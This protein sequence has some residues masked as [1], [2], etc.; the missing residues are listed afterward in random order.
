[1]LYQMQKTLGLYLKK[2]EGT[3]NLFHLSIQKLKVPSIS[4][5][6]WGGHST[7]L[8]CL[9]GTLV[10]S[11]QCPLVHCWCTAVHL[12]AV[13]MQMQPANRGALEMTGPQ[14]RAE[15]DLEPN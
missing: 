3:I 4:N 15:L 1:M 7:F 5:V 8:P 14:A 9:G 6:Q 12:S 10:H 2:R 11:V 13:Q